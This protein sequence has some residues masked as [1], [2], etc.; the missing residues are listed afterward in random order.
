MALVPCMS[1][2]GNQLFLNYFSL[3]FYDPWG[4]WVAPPP[5]SQRLRGWLILEFLEGG[6]SVFPFLGGPWPEPGDTT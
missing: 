2:L 4:G 1:Y 6:C 5:F 3:G